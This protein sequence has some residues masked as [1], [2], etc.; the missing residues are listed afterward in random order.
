VTMVITRGSFTHRA[1]VAVASGPHSF[2]WKP[3]AAGSYR[4]VI[5]ARDLAGNSSTVDSAATVRRRR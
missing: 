4:I 1:V 2:G 5:S 3:P